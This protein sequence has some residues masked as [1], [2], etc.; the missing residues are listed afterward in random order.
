MRPLPS[1]LLLVLLSTTLLLSACLGE[2]E[3]SPSPP[4]TCPAT[5]SVRPP[6]T[7]IVANDRR[8]TLYAPDNYQPGK[9]YPL[10]VSLHPFMT[11]PALWEAYSHLAAAARARGY[12]VLLPRGSDP[13]PR[14][15]VPGGYPDGSDMQWLDALVANTQSQVCVD[16]QRIFA[17]GFS[18]GAAMAV[19]LSCQSASPYRAIAASGGANLTTLCPNAAAVDALIL[20][21]SADP[22]APL[23]GSYVIFAP[24]L[25]ITL[26]SVLTSFAQ[27][28]GC[29]GSPQIRAQTPTLN[30]ARYACGHQRL[31]YWRM[32]GAGH[33]WGGAEFPLD[34][35][36]GPTDHSF[37]ANAA[38]LDFFAASR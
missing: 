33:T 20:H 36:T 12:W 18:A 29:K 16:K 37:S 22:I 8:A 25:G 28:N 10:L 17:A 23:T 5:S 35:I 19:A 3:A 1:P 34:P 4:Q 30:V 13:G 24:P 11:D 9:A 15:S 2:Q 6:P 31:E 26:D 7:H 38:V 21:G 32:E 27:R 14:W